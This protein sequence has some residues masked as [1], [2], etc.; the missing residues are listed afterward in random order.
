MK[1][2]FQITA[3][4]LLLVASA[5]LALGVKADDCG[6]LDGLG[7]LTDRHPEVVAACESVVRFEGRRYLR[8]GAELRAFGA[9]ELVLRF[10]GASDDVA[11][12]LGAEPPVV[13]AD[14]APGL[15]AD[16]PAGSPLFV[17]VPEDRVLEVFADVSTISQPRVPVAVEQPPSDA[18]L[19]ARIA[20]YTC[21]PRRRPPYIYILPETASPLAAVG[22]LGLGLLATGAALTRHRLRRRRAA[23]R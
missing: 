2:L 16:A 18:A 6:R 17:Y 3:A 10:K 15:A 14:A 7:S 4:A 1:P 21:C 8:L 23:G 5:A 12:S 20:N 11:L 9:E 19:K 22:L 13:P